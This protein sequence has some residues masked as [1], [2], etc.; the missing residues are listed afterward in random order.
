MK[1][2]ISVLLVLVMVFC[3]AACGGGSGDDSEGGGSSGSFRCPMCG[4]YEELRTMPVVGWFV[5]IVHFFVHMAYRIINAST[6]FSG[7]FSF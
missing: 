7:K 2:A 4:A 5:A 6:S 1:K 3:L